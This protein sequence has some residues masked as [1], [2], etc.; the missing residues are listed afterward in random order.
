[1][2]E[3]SGQELKDYLFHVRDLEL[4]CYKQQRYINRLRGLEKQ[5]KNPN[6]IASKSKV[7]DEFD[8]VTKIVTLIIAGVIGLFLGGIIGGLLVGIIV[9]IEFF[10]EHREVKKKNE[11]ID[12]DNKKAEKANSIFMEKG[13]QKAAVVNAEIQK[14]TT[15]LRATE[16]TLAQLYSAGVVY[17]KYQGLIPIT[18]FCEYVASGR[19][20]ELTGHEGAYN[21]YENEIRLNLIIIKLDDIINKLDEIQQN[22]YMLSDMIR[23]TNQ[24]LDSLSNIAVQQA[25]SLNRIE[26]NTAVASYYSGISAMNTTYLAWA[27]QHNY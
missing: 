26:S 13:N 20:T 12:S 24:Q 23:K 7:T 16:Q 15:T 3:L 25:Q 4:S 10:R 19:C 2:A 8:I 18:M 27:K 11:K 21:I 6:L 22:Q 5:A 9:I 14:T 17:Q 1:M